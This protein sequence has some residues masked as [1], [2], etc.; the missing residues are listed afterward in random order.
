[1]QCIHIYGTEDFF[2]SKP[3]NHIANHTFRHNRFGNQSAST[4]WVPKS[5]QMRSTSIHTVTDQYVVFARLN[6]YVLEEF[7]TILD[8]LWEFHCF[9]TRDDIP[10]LLKGDRNKIRPWSAQTGLQPCPNDRR[11]YGLVSLQYCSPGYTTSCTIPS[12]HSR[13]SEF[14]GAEF[15]VV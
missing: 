10:I 6:S 1:L 9:I 15:C 8:D 11:L 13:I 12:E 14:C 4:L 7:P 2:L 5:F 3:S